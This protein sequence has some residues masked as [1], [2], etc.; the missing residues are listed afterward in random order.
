MGN[1]RLTPAMEQFSKSIEDLNLIDLPLEGG[2]YTWSSG[3]D[4]PLM[5]RIDRALVSHDWE[6]HYPD[7]IQRILPRLVSDHF[8]ILVEV[9]GMARGKSPF[10]FEN[11]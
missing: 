3:L 9:G 8:P 10:R 4:Q 6:E 5:S 1:S 7:V 11:M 2:S